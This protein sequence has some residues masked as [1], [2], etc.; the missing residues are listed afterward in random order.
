MEGDARAGAVS[1]S[2]PPLTLRCRLR[3]GACRYDPPAR[4]GRQP[5][6]KSHGGDPQFAQVP[7]RRLRPPHQTHAGS[8]QMVMRQRELEE[9][10]SDELW[11]SADADW[12]V[13]PS[14]SRIPQQP[15]KSEALQ[16]G[17]DQMIAEIVLAAREPDINPDQPPRHRLLPWRM[18]YLPRQRQKPDVHHCGFSKPCR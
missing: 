14:L 15:E 2:S 10:T 12:N 6:Y 4:T 16:W 3:H 17:R 8:S 13:S 5:W 11:N 9:S 1:Q 18:H 7:A